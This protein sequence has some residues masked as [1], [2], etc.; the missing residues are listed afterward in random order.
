MPELAQYRRGSTKGFTL[1]EL[2]VVIVILAIILAIAVP[3]LIGYIDRARDVQRQAEA[4][5]VGQAIVSMFILEGVDLN[6]ASQS[7]FYSSGDF[8]FGAPD[9][10][11]TVAELA[12]VPLSDIGFPVSAGQWRPLGSSN[13][14]IVIHL[15]NNPN[16]NI[17]QPGQTRLWD[18][19]TAEES[20][21]IFLCILVGETGYYR[22]QL[23]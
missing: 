22:I 12:G 20:S 5:N 21:T 23:K 7:S 2:I 10:L 3:A 9:R 14:E 17:K 8:Q 6:S 4:R 11:A 19:K 1:V 15:T 18:T 16:P 13:P